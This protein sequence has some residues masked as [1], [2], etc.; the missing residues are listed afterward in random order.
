MRNE[1]PRSPSPQ[2]PS[3][4]CASVAIASSSACHTHQRARGTFD[5]ARICAQGPH[6]FGRRHQAS[7]CG[8]ENSSGCSEQ[9]QRRGQP[10]PGF[11]NSKTILNLIGEHRQGL[12][13]AQIRLKEYRHVNSRRKNDRVALIA[14]TDSAINMCVT[15]RD[16]G[17]QALVASAFFASD[18]SRRKVISSAL[19]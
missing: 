15:T 13:I 12:V 8:G 5:T 10:R 9:M 2:K 18:L 6:A 4:A 14:P 3:I 11:E 17:G 7:Y 19:H 16:P 1:A